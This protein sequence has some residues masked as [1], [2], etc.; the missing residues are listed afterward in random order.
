MDY[1]ISFK[2]NAEKFLRDF[3]L[4]FRA[5]VGV[6][7]ICALWRSAGLPEKEPWIK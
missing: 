1:Y 6:N 3:S 4:F 2:E 5:T 7:R